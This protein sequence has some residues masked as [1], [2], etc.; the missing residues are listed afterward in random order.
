MK[1]EFGRQQLAHVLGE[2]PPQF[3]IV[4]G[5]GLSGFVEEMQISREIPYHAVVGLPRCGV[6]GHEGRFVFGSLG[7]ISLVAA[8]GRV[9]LY[10][11]KSAREVTAQIR[12]L[13]AAGVETVFLTNA[14]GTV[15]PTL[16]A[17]GWMLLKDHLNLTGTS[18]LLGGPD[19]VDLTEVYDSSL[20]LLFLEK[21]KTLG[22][23]LPEGVYAGVTGP[24]YETSAEIRMLKVL[25][26]DAVGMSTVLEA[27]QARALGMRVAAFS[28]LTN[29]G[30]GLSDQVIDHKDVLNQTKGCARE[31]ARLLKE[32]LPVLD[33]AGDE[34]LQR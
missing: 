32:T 14:A 22:L 25:G 5:S 21:A 15:N 26:A 9:H 18:P 27:I 31:L 4:L 2:D 16:E 20:R 28:C 12:C 33:G 29:P 23:P 30:A 7:A 34:M 8:C 1:N 13:A 3:A 11:G 24:H 10:E 17:G 19:F 6:P